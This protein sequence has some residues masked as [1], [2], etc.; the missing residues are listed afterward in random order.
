M[1]YIAVPDLNNNVINIY[2]LTNDKPPVPAL[3]AAI[4]PTLADGSSVNPNSVVLYQSNDLSPNNFWYM[5][6]ADTTEGCIAI[7]DFTQIAPA[8]QAATPASPA[9]IPATAI[10]T[11]SS[12]GTPIHVAIQPGTGDLYAAF[13]AAVYGWTRGPLGTLPY[14]SQA[15]FLFCSP[16]GVNICA[17]LAFDLHGNLWLSTFQSDTTETAVD[18]CLYCFTQVDSNPGSSA[19]Y[20]IIGN[21]TS[22]STPTALPASTPN[23]PTTPLKSAPDGGNSQPVYPLSQPEG[24]AFDPLG[25]LWVA[26]NNDG[27]DTANPPTNGVN[28]GTL[29]KI[30]W[31]WIGK[32][33]NY[34]NLNQDTTAPGMLAWGG[35]QP[36]NP[37]D[38]D[39]TV[40]YQF[41]ARYGG[42]SFDGFEL[43]VHDQNNGPYDPSHAVVW[44]CDTSTDIS[45]AFDPLGNFAAKSGI[46]TDY[47]GNGTTAIFTI[48]PI[49]TQPLQLVIRDG[50]WDSATKLNEPDVIPPGQHPWESPDIAVTAKSQLPSVL[51]QGDHAPADIPLPSDPMVYY[52]PTFVQVRVTNLGAVDTTGKEVLKLYWGKGSVGLDWPTPFDGLEFDVTTVHPALGGLIAPPQELGTIR[53]GNEKFF[54]F[55]WSAPDS[56]LYSID[57]GHFC[58][59]ARIESSSLYPFGMTYQ[60][61]TVQTGPT[62]E[63]HLYY[64]AAQNAR[65]AWRNVHIISSDDQIHIPPGGGPKIKFPFHLGVIGANYGPLAKNFRFAVETLGRDGKPTPVK[66]EV[67]VHAQGAA[68]QR[69]RETKVE[70]H[71]F[72]YIGDGRFRMRDPARGVENVRLHPGETLPF[73]VEFTPPEDMRNFAVRVVQYVDFGGVQKVVGGQTFVVGHVEGFPTREKRETLSESSLAGR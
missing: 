69:L 26:N 56:K 12:S 29:L 17:N 58:L 53:A 3:V 18:D 41:N 32:L 15:P 7:F 46:I 5:F 36:I 66:G 60:E 31:Q 64:N 61:Q 2:S 73:H 62:S 34:A 24:I 16:S 19:K 38:P 50:T 55:A 8:V 23:W 51:P 39:V 65:I 13:G 1:K 57:D 43:Y 30:G 48:D 27:T 25:N 4:T 6:V 59:L 11:L 20:F 21:G 54:E 9:A 63:P 70:E 52:G 22:T 33:L 47:P 45:G 44:W 37:T 28:N 49:D 42:L 71:L 67:V 35:T 72:E 10:Q 14:Y 40:Y 68:L